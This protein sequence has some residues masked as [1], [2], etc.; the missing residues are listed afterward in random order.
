[1]ELF[2]VSLWALHKCELLSTFLWAFLPSGGHF[3]VVFTTSFVAAPVVVQGGS[4]Y[5]T[6][7]PVQTSKAWSSIRNSQIKKNNNKKKRKKK[8]G[9][10]KSQSCHSPYLTSP[11]SGHQLAITLFF[12][13]KRQTRDGPKMVQSYQQQP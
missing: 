11:P 5:Y 8:E 10:G 9:E 12:T 3:V 1:L 4:P 7:Q 2:W 13:S 6:L